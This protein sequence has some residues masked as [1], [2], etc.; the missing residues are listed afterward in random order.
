MSNLFLND[1][2]PDEFKDSLA[3]VKPRCWTT[4]R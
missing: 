4:T 2:L 1:A 3:T